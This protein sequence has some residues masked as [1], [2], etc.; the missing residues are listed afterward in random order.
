MK[1]GDITR[2]LC[3]CIH[4]TENGLLKKESLKKRKRRRGRRRETKLRS[5]K[6]STDNFPR[7]AIKTFGEISDS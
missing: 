1:H 4:C 7:I 2:Q 5:E 6:S 3:N